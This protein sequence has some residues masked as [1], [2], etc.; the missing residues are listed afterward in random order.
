VKTVGWTLVPVLTAGLLA[1]LGCRE[2][3]SP[4]APEPA[5]ALA[6]ATAALAFAQLSASFD[7]TCGV[8]TD[9]RAFCWGSNSEGGGDIGDG[10]TSNRLR[11][12]LVRGGHSFRQVSA[13]W[14]HTCGV[15]TATRRIAGVAI[16]AASSAPARSPNS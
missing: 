8:T 9:H 16:S 6:T 7:H 12:A 10:T 2:D 5:P 11:P 3:E 13:S 1:T 4:T 15:I 14:V